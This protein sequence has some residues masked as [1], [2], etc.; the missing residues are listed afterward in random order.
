MVVMPVMYLIADCVVYVIVRETVS[1]SEVASEV[2]ISE[3]GN[4]DLT[5][6]R[7][8]Y[9]SHLAHLR[10]AIF[11]RFRPLH[12][13]SLA[14]ILTCSLTSHYLSLPL[15][16]ANS[17]SVKV[18]ITVSLLSIFCS[19]I[20]SAVLID[21]PHLFSSSF[22][23]FVDALR[24]PLTVISYSIRQRYQRTLVITDYSMLL[25][26]VHIGLSWIVCVSF[27]STSQAASLNKSC[28][29]QLSWKWYYMTCHQEGLII[30]LCRTA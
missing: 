1:S 16:T 15:V 3:L 11:G 17:S 10:P 8:T 29:Q 22:I 30:C 14:S 23:I 7:V 2:A 6:V 19:A 4:D 5:D 24:L 9:V 27:S 25:I 13:C 20:I 21:H 26:N 12:L 28:P 18:V